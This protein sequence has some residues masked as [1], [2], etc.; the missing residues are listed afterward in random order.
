MNDIEIIEKLFRRTELFSKQQLINTVKRS[1]E[2]VGTERYSREAKKVYRA[3]YDDLLSLI[4]KANLPKLTEKWWF[5]S[6]NTSVE[7]INIELCNASD[8]IVEDNMIS[9]MTSDYW[10]TIIEVKASY[11]SVEEYSKLHKVSVEVVEG[12][13]KNGDLESIIKNNKSEW[14]ISEL[15]CRPTRSF[16]S[17]SYMISEKSNICMPEFPLVNI[18]KEIYI[19]REMEKP[20]GYVCVFSDKDKGLCIEMKLSKQKVNR[21][22]YLLNTS[23]EAK[24][25]S[26]NNTLPLHY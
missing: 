8:F 26:F 24:I 20:R 9:S 18:S 22:R 25:E 15:E 12:W 13:I 16:W 23:K 5:Y 21:L 2:C 11:I 4:N 10:E 7:S 6:L 14:M 3:Y 1:R 19:R 17:A